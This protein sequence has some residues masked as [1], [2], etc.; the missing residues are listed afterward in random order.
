MYIDEYCHSF[1]RLAQQ[2]QEASTKVYQSKEDG[3]MAVQRLE[4]EISCGGLL[5]LAPDPL[6]P[7]ANSR[8]RDVELGG[9]WKGKDE[10]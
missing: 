8:L 1:L 5:V 3:K 6:V 7:F 9:F 4:A 10:W 2:L